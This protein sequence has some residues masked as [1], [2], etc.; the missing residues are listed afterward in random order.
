MYFF[1]SLIQ[2]MTVYK[3]LSNLEQI[4]SETAGSTKKHTQNITFDP[5]SWYNLW[6]AMIV[7]QEGKKWS[8]RHHVLYYIWSCCINA[9][10]NF[11]VRKSLSFS[12]SMIHIVVS[13]ESL[14]ECRGRSQSY[15]FSLKHSEKY[16][17]RV[18][19]MCLVYL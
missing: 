4:K 2:A 15:S 3:N 7:V 11:I 10:I 13:L 9:E 6:C 16:M 1:S 18:T 12:V 19:I 8:L 14:L 17:Y 5:E